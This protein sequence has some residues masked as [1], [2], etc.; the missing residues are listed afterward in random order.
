MFAQIEFLVLC[1]LSLHAFINVL[2]LCIWLICDTAT[3]ILLCWFQ[4]CT[5]LCVVNSNY[6]FVWCF[7]V[8]EILFNISILFILIYHVCGQDSS[9][10]QFLFSCSDEYVDLLFLTLSLR[11]QLS[12][13]NLGMILIIEIKGKN[14]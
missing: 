14:S 2:N 5:I 10:G 1:W 4:L 8:T 9:L 6:W 12:M 11:F 7:Y 3:I 13:N